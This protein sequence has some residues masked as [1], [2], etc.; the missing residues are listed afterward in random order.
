MAKAFNPPWTFI[1]WIAISL[2]VFTK[3]N[4]QDEVEIVNSKTIDEANDS[5]TAPVLVNLI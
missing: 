5:D 1:N 3:I 4:A 2:I